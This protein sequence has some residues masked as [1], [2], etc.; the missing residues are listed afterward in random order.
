[1]K[2]VLVWGKYCIRWFSS[3]LIVSRAVHRG[4][5]WWL[6]PLS[7]CPHQLRCPSHQPPITPAPPLTS[8]PS[9]QLPL[10][11]T[12]HHPSSPSHQ[13]PITPAPPLTNPPSPH[14]PPITP[15]P[16][17]TN[18]P[19]PQLKAF[20]YRSANPLLVFLPASQHHSQSV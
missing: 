11:P 7:L 1:M 9:P 16:P 10:S 20:C 19:S 6:E 3:G 13:P 12:P 14:Q 4:V 15:A 17:L 18:P 5:A 8:P 2:S